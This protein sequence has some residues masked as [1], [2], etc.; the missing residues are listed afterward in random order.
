ML[1]PEDLGLFGLI[2]TTV[3]IFGLLIGADLYLPV[4]RDILATQPEQRAKKFVSQFSF[5]SVSFLVLSPAFFW[6]CDRIEIS[7]ALILMTLPVLL[8]DQ[9]SMELHRELI[10]LKEPIDANVVYLLRSGLWVYV[11]AVCYWVFD[12]APT[13]GS[14]LTA[15]MAGAALAV[16]VGLLRLNRVLEIKLAALEVDWIWTAKNLRLAMPFLVA[17]LA[18]KAVEVGDRYII[19][20]L[21]GLAPLG[22]FTLFAGI[23]G[24]I[25]LVAYAGSVSLLYPNLVTAHTAHDRVAFRETARSMCF[26]SVL[27]SALAVLA[28]YLL[29]E[30]LLAFVD[31]AEYVDS[32]AMLW[33]LVGAMV[34][35]V[36]SQQAHFVLYARGHDKWITIPSLLCAPLAIILNLTLIPIHGITGAAYTAAISAAFLLTVKTYAVIRE[37]AY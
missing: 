13:L 2:G 28:I 18:L 15:W 30:P 1:Q 37:K 19:E 24:F 8:F 5:Y 34:I 29:I 10:A 12:I 3:L 25:N 14:V 33:Y 6:I 23:A 35:T 26:R 16:F 22:V 36:L 21:I 9:L 7:T 20:A 4:H 32:L 27:V 17:T 11:L 31:R